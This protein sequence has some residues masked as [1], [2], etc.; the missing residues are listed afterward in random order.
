M[1]DKTKFDKV[2]LGV[3][4]WV[5]YDKLVGDTSSA[6]P[7]VSVGRSV[8]LVLS[9]DRRPRWRCSVRDAEVF[10]T[11]SMSMA[12]G[13][14]AHPAASPIPLRFAGQ[15]VVIVDNKVFLHGPDP[16]RLVA[17]AREQGVSKPHVLFAEPDE[18]DVVTFG[19]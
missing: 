3:P 13:R 14:E 19:M 11:G 2:S 15:W 7:K 12:G 9:G 10:E 4:A 6:L 18:A 8:G 17:L 1:E 16:V 5:G